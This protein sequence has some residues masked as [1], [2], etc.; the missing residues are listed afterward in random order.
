MRLPGGRTGKRAV[1][2][3]D[4]GLT[5]LMKPFDTEIWFG[6]RAGGSAPTGRPGRRT[7]P[8]R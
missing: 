2:V 5:G 8:G 7:R 1:V 6:D 3:D 4:L